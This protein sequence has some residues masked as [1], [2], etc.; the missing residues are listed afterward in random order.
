ML[1]VTAMFRS[2]PLRPDRFLSAHC[3]MLWFHRRARLWPSELLC[4]I[5]AFEGRRD[6]PEK[7]W[8]EM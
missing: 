8:R 6:V 2:V 7:G 4:V 3:W 1:G 5:L